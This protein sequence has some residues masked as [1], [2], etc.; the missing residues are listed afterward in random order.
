MRLIFAL[1]ILVVLPSCEEIDCPAGQKSQCDFIF[2]YT[3]NCKCVKDDNYGGDET[4]LEWHA[5]VYCNR[6]GE[7]T[8]IFIG[9]PPF[10]PDKPLSSVRISASNVGSQVARYC[11]DGTT[12][13][14]ANLKVEQWER[15][16][17]AYAAVGRVR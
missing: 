4:P 12:L 1:L 17:G 9:K 11:A 8:A 10:F 3:K 14:S 7:G 5:D 13:M 15:V 2:G 6:S 16:D